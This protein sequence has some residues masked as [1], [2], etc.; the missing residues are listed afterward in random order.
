MNYID[1]F[2]KL[3]DK[4]AWFGDTYMEK[5]S[6][7]TEKEAFT[8]PMKGV[9]TIAELVS[10]VIF[11]RTP[12]IR[13]LRGEKDYVADGESADNW[14]SLEKLKAKGWKPLLGDFEKSQNELVS[15]LKKTKPE[16]F[17]R[18]YTPGNS[19]DYVTEGI[20][21]H[22]VYHLGQLALVKK[23]IRM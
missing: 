15:L 21:Q 1:N 11:W 2:T 3:Y 4:G 8:A 19:W 13:K 14:V 16:F 7:V 18:E 12:L 23:M 5:L 22:D 20:V 10:H 6:D 9:H 17:E